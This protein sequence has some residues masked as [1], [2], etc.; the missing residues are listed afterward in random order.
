MHAA[1]RWSRIKQQPKIETKVLDEVAHRARPPPV[2]HLCSASHT[3][4]K[5]PRRNAL[6]LCV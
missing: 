4:S 3:T 2:L 1:G 5:M 6:P